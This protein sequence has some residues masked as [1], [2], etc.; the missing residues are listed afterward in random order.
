MLLRNYTCH[1]EI[2]IPVNS[3]Y[4]TSQFLPL[5]GQET[6]L[7]TI[8]NSILSKFPLWLLSSP[9][10]AAEKLHLSHW[11]LHLCEQ[12]PYDFSVSPSLLPGNHTCH[13]NKFHPCEIFFLTPELTLLCC[14]EITL[15]TLKSPSLWTVSIWLFS[16]SL[17]PGKHTCHNN[18]WNPLKFSLWLLSSP[19]YAAEKLHL[20]H[21]NIN[22]CE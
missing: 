11:N 16:F 9:F 12:P 20:S 10:Y 17:L 21:W 7:I 8:I 5:C 13:N 1:I 4:M 19:F 22:L 14:W 3:L 15:V 6:T 2:S 18:K